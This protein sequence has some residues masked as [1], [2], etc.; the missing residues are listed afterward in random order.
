[1]VKIDMESIGLMD[2]YVQESSLYSDLIIGR[3][4]SQSKDCYGVITENG[5]VIARI[6]GKFRYKVRLLGDYPAVGDFVMIDEDDSNN[7]G[8]TVSYT[9]LTLPT[10]PYV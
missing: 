10:T 5:E 7:N 4:S 3:V 1:M 2:K 6:S 8:I 9:H